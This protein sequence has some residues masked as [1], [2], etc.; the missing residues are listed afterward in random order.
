MCGTESPRDWYDA[1][2]E[3]KVGAFDVHLG[4]LCGI[5]VEKDLDMEVADRKYKGRAY[6][7]GN[8]VVGL[9]CC[10]DMAA[11]CARERATFYEDMG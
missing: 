11:S 7:L 9:L 10:V 3:G 6:V 4:H 5:C 8:Q 2:Q 1:R